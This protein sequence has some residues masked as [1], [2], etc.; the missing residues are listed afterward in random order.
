MF[1]PVKEP[2]SGETIKMYTRKGNI[3][4]KRGLFVTNIDNITFERHGVMQC[5]LE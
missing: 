1:H 2:S 4:R 5:L 3:K